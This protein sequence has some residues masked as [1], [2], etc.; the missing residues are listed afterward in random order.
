MKNLGGLKYFLSIEVA[1]LEQDIF[2][3]QRNYR[4]KKHKVVALSSAEVEFRDSSDFH[5]SLHKS[6]IK[7]IYA[8]I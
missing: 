3:S 7:D 8:P 2:L 4:S 6:G 5:N 1:R